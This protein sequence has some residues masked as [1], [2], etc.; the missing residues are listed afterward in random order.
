MLAHADFC[1]V[2]RLHFAPL[3]RTEIEWFHLFSSKSLQNQMF[4]LYIR[5]L[6]PSASIHPEDAVWAVVVGSQL[7][8]LAEC[9][10]HIEREVVAIVDLF[11]TTWHIGI[12]EGPIIST[13]YVY[14]RSQLCKLTVNLCR[15]LSYGQLHHVSLICTLDLSLSQQWLWRG[16]CIVQQNCTD[17]SVFRLNVLDASCV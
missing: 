13:P 6:I 2:C 17:A 4:L 8:T 7:Y 5:P 9:L 3:Q 14:N 1:M 11:P 12:V 15:L 16:C 10:Q